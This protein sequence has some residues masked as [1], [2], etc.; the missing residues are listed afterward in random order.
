MGTSLTSW[1]SCAGQEIR[2]RSRAPEE[3]RWGRPRMQR[4][5]NSGGHGGE[6]QQGATT[7]SWLGES[8]AP[9]GVDDF[10]DEGRGEHAAVANIHGELRREKRCGGGADE[11]ER[12]REI[13]MAW[14]AEWL[15]VVAMAE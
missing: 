7:R 1:K 10:E 4:Q 5:E 12:E 2:T 11:P 14:R 15:G 6:L 3:Q 8:R 9:G 13:R